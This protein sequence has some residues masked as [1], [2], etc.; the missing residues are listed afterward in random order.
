[1][2]HKL[3]DKVLRRGK[4]TPSRE[5]SDEVV[6]KADDGKRKWD[7]NRNQNQNQQQK[8]NSSN[9]N[10]R[11]QRVCSRCYK[12]HDGFCSVTCNRCSN[13]GHVA[14]DCKV[15]I[16]N[17][18]PPAAGGGNG[19][20]NG[21]SKNSGAQRVCYECGKPGHFRDTC[22][23]KKKPAENVRG[24]AFNINT[25]DAEEDLKLVTG[26]FSVNDLSVYVLFDSGADLSFVSN[27]FSPKIK[28]PLTPLDR[29]YAVEVANGKVLTAKTVYRKCNIKL[30]DRDFKVDLVPIE[31]VSFDVVIG[32]DWLSENR[33]EIVCY[34]KAA[35]ITR[36]V[37]ELLMVFG[38]KK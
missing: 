14:Q 17:A 31:L 32:M 37:G 16:P 15:A 29:T 26:T 19:N 10:N 4:K 5:A 25:R 1:M 38:D 28:T 11:N 27:K 24:R 36:V 7:N 8:Q 23:D 2:V 21:K 30:A 20:S 12:S 3:N 13:Q 22:P 6:K 33:A 34:E 18:A 35:R 9:S